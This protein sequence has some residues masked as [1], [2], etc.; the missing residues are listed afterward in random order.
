LSV[1]GQEDTAA[2]LAREGV[3]VIAS[4]P[5]HGPVNVE[6]QRGK[7][8][9]EKSLQGLRQLNALGYAADGS[10]LLLDLVYNPVGAELPPEQ[11]ALEADYKRELG[12]LGIRFNRLLTLTNMPIK[13]FR[14]QLERDGDYARY[15]DLLVGAFVQDNLAHLMCRSLLSVDWR[16][17]VYDCDFNQML[18]LPAAGQAGLHLRDLMQA[19]W[20]QRPIAVGDHCFGCSAG[21]GSSCG[22]ALSA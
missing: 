18:E 21:R 7:G 16:G 22:G 5:C 20:P 15:M 9:F 19:K 17:Y 1:P 3:H 14:H 13:R 6:R 2:F 12:R 10:G 8:V 11:S 4:L